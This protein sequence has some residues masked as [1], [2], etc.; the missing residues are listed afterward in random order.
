MAL[1]AAATEISRSGIQ[2][3]GGAA[4][5][6]GGDTFANTGREFL[7][8]KNADAS[9][10]TV[11]IDY[12]P[13]ADGQ[14]VP[15]KTVIIP[16]GQTYLIGPFPPSLYNNASGQVSVTYSA[17]TSVTVKVVRAGELG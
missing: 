6:G 2:A 16:A 8:V 4:A 12:V 13:T 5:S 14:T 11:T 3:D 7:A 15:D 17:V 9:A 1:L 10:K